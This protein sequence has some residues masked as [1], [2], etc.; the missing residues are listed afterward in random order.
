MKIH[1]FQQN[2]YNIV[3]DIN[4]GAVHVTDELIYDLLDVFTGDNDDEAVAALKDKYDEADLRDGLEDLHELMDRQELFA[5]DLNVPLALKN[6]PLVKS[7]CLH[8]AHDCNLRCQ[9]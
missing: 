5:P 2:G 1:K 7:L 6:K 9:Y 4:S 8:V 3:L